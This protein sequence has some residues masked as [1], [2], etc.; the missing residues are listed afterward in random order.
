MVDPE[1][2]K[3]VSRGTLVVCAVSLVGQWCQEAQKKLDGSLVM[4]PYHGSSR[5]R[6]PM[7]LATGY[8][9]VV[10]TYA[11]LSSDYGKNGSGVRNPLHKIKWHR[12]VFDEGVCVGGGRNTAAVAM[13]V[14]ILLVSLWCGAV[15]WQTCRKPF[16]IS[17]DTW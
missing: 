17:S 15:V 7:R 6:D 16:L 8:D 10:T 3:I 2:S 4:Y 14:C 5:I 13:A 11:T 9:L 1:S 12:V